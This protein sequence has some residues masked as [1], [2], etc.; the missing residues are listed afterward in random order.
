LINVSEGV[1]TCLGVA[2][3]VVPPPTSC[4]LEAENNKTKLIFTQ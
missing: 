3:G 1:L 2:I 4:L